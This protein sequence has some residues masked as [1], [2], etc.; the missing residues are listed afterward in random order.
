MGEIRATPPI[1]LSF[2]Q[3][4]RFGPYSFAS[5]ALGLQ[6]GFVTPEV[7][8]KL[9]EEKTNAVTDRS[10]LR[11][12]ASFWDAIANGEPSENHSRVT[13]V[14]RDL[15]ES[16]PKQSLSAQRRP[17]LKAFVQS[18]LDRYDDPI[19]VLEAVD[20][21]HAVLGY[22]D[23]LTPLTTYRSDR[24]VQVDLEDFGPR[25]AGLSERAVAEARRNAMTRFLLE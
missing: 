7:L 5:L 22:P 8:G 3:A 17:W 14:L 4:N 2:E 19:K 23:E 13:K 10:V 12:L 6:E 21:L 15:A 18:V 24:G 25:G 11:Q 9:L 16:E 1:V 20:I